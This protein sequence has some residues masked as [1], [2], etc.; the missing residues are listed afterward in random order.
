MAKF[1]LNGK[2]KRELEKMLK[3]IDAE[4]AR[5]EKQKRKDALKAARAAAAEFG[6]SLED[7]LAAPTPKAKRKRSG[8]RGPQPA[9][10]QDAASGKTWSG[11]GRPPAWFKDHVDAGKPESDLLIA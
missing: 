11:M 6:F 7:L 4:F 10:Y 5:R 1:D 8:P 2:T 9:K 3:D